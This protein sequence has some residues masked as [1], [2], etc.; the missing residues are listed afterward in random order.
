MPRALLGTVAVATLLYIGI[1][2]VLTGLVPYTGLDVADPISRAL[3][4]AGPLGWL[5]DL[6]GIA[7][8]VGLFAT[9]L[10]TLYGQVRILMRM[11]AD[12]L[13]PPVFARIDP[14]RRTPVGN[15]LFCAAGRGDGRR[16]RADR[17]AR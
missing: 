8:V 12:G 9:V 16:P 14:R 2:L 1:A 3:A 10:V 17:R 6:V 15:T 13:L 11:S 5:D 4:A 7:A